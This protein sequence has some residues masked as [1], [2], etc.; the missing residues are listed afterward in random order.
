MRGYRFTNYKFRSGIDDLK[1][2]S[3]S[4]NLNSYLLK[5]V[6]LNFTYEGI[7]ENTRTSGR[8]LANLTYRF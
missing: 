2:N 6:L 8:F 3:V 4:I 5:P 7:F 1:Q